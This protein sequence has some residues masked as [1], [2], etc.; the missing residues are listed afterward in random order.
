MA[1]DAELGGM[2]RV[3][4]PMVVRMGRKQMETDMANL[5]ELLEAQE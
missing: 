4:E 1:A 3:A 2:F 5:K